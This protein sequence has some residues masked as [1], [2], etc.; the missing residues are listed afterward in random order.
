VVLF[1]RSHSLILPAVSSPRAPARP[2]W[3]A[4][5]TVAVIGAGF[6]GVLTAVHL[7]RAPPGPRVILIER[8]NRFGRGA[9][10]ATAS[11][12]HLLNVRGANMSALPDA[13]AHFLEWLGEDAGDGERVFVTRDRYG[14]YLQALLRQAASDSA[15]R[16][17]LEHDEAV[18]LARDGD[19]WAVGLA[20][21]RTLRADAVVVAVG[22]LPPQTPSGVAADLLASSR[23]VADPWAWIERD[24]GAITGDVLLVGSGLTAVDVGLAVQARAPG[25]RVLALSRH[26]LT[27]RAHAPIESRRALAAAPSGSLAHVFREVRAAGRDDWRAAIDALRPHV[28]TLWRRWNLEQRRRFLRHARPWWEVSRHRL[29][30]QV[31]TQLSRLSEA[32]LF[33]VAAP[34]GVEATWTPRGAPAPVRRTFSLA[35]NCAG[36]LSDVERSEDP[37]IESLIGGGLA[38]PDACRLGLDVDEQ[39]RAIGADGAP[40]VGLFAVGPLSRGQVYEMTSVP[41]IRIQAAEVA[42]ALLAQLATM[43]APAGGG[44]DRA[45]ACAL[46]AYLDEAVAELA[47]EIEEKTASRRAR[48]AWELRGRQAAL[49]ELRAWLSQRDA[50]ATR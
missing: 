15:G 45:L 3:P 34:G 38:R 25:V 9:A 29:A 19:A 39:S 47:L 30:P 48:S 36:P 26:G 31:D 42:Q 8:G 24:Q 5:H 16:L 13:P 22:N 27:P 21:G 40:V 6:S 4:G 33:L 14:A 41:D 20:M 7:L 10:Y 49:E 44:G 50:T 28:Q 23:W 2:T 35:I 11:P 1:E 12:H 18:A 17:S 46:Q 32:G 37:L 43:A